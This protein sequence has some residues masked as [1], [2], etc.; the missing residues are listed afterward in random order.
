MKKLLAL[1]LLMFLLSAAAAAVL[2]TLKIP[3]LEIFDTYC[4][5]YGVERCLAYAVAK[6]ESGFLP[7]AVSAKD[8]RG[9]MQLTDDTAVWCAERLSEPQLAEMTDDPEV[10]I[11]LGI[12][13]LSYLL[14]RYGGEESAALSAYNAGA[15]H[16]DEWLGDSACSDDGRRIVSAPYP[17]TERYLKRVAAYKKIYR[18]L[19]WGDSDVQGVDTGL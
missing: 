17:E 3:D 9:I 12:Y 1:S 15:A 11:R 14:E 19:Y 2:G 8:A 5:T 16:V 10:N 13:Y 6:T 4:D 18:M 7:D